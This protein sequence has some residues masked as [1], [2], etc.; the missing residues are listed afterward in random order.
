MPGIRYLQTLSGNKNVPGVLEC[1]YL[2]GR[3]HRGYQYRSVPYVAGAI[4]L[5][6]A[7]HWITWSNFKLQLKFT[8]QALLDVLV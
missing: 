3:H 5:L 1:F 2:A 8:H 6:G 4:L 7:V